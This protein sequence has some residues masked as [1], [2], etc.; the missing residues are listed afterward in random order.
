M[1]KNKKVALIEIDSDNTITKIYKIIDINYA[2]LSFK[3]ALEKK[4]ISNIK[5]LNE[6]FKGRGIPSWRKDI[7]DLLEKLNITSLNV[8]T[9]V[10]LLDKAFGLSLSDQYWI[11]E[12]IKIYYGKI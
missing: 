5:A 11:K 6:W 10:E 3:N 12:E 4:D 1:N 8:D 9:P 7:E 2:P